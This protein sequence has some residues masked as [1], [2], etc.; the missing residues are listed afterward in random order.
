MKNPN[1]TNSHEYDEYLVKLTKDYIGDHQELIRK[2]PD[3]YRTITKLIKSEDLASE[4]R[5]LLFIVAGYFLIPDDLYPEETLGAEGF[6]DDILL[7]LFVFENIQRKYGIEFLSLNSPFDE[8]DI[9]VI[10]DKLYTDCR[11]NNL[12]IYSNVLKYTGL[13]DDSEQ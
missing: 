2:T 13:I 5:Q 4:D 1:D 12:N 8:E 7:A 11:I 10:M 3:I 6:I 9:S